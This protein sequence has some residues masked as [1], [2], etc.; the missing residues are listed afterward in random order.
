MEGWRVLLALRCLLHFRCPRIPAVS[1][2]SVLLLKIK[3]FRLL[4]GALYFFIRGSLRSKLFED[5][6]D[7][8]L[9]VSKSYIPEIQGHDRWHA[10]T[11]PVPRP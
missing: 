6:L 2:N 1:R 10:R 9:D 11:R 7:T 8:G 3:L 5:H 4:H